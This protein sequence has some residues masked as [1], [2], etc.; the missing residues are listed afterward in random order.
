[1]LLETVDG[2][3]S[4]LGWSHT[5]RRPDSVV[6]AQRFGIHEHARSSKIAAGTSTSKPF[7][8]MKGMRF[9]FAALADG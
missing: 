5:A 2:G 4:V 3:F 1:L 7:A 9:C 8:A 6:R